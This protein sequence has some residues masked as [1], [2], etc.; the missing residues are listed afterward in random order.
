MVQKLIEFLKS[1]M[2][3]L[4]TLFIIF[5]FA[6][7]IPL[8]IAPN[9]ETDKVEVARK[10]KRD[11]PN[12]YAF[13][14]EDPKNT[15]EFYNFINTKFELNFESVKSNVPFFINDIEY[16][17]TF[18]EREKATKTVNLVPLAIDGALKNKGNDAMLED[19]YT[20]R[21][22]Q[23]FVIVTVRNNQNQDCLSPNYEQRDAV[24]HYLRDLRNEY[25]T[26]SDYEISR[27]RNKLIK[28]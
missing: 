19:S 3:A 24:V 18:Y 16:A 6:G 11:L 25:L 23:W 22:G 20:S 7:C 28:H 13:I 1:I 14:F 15:D 4:T 21:V 9:I 27:L 26:T 2:K 10:F 12:Q 5:F 8:K 17:L